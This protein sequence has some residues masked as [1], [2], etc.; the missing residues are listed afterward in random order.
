MYRAVGVVGCVHLCV[1]CIFHFLF[2][3]YSV[4]L[5]ARDCSCIMCIHVYTMLL[6]MYMY[7]H[8][9]VYTMYTCT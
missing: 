5:Y 1:L 2:S 3:Q 4:V 6:Y 8:V 7:I 9:H